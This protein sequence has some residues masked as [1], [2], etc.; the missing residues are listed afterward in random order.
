MSTLRELRHSR[1]GN[2]ILAATVVLAV[3]L[4]AIPAKAPRK[5]S[6]K[7]SLNRSS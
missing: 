2:L 6:S 1:R 5:T 4:I 3:A 7:A